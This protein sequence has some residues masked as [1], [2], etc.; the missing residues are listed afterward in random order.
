MVLQ[1]INF[2]ISSVEFPFYFP[3]NFLFFLSF[4]LRLLRAA[5]S[6]ALVS[7]SSFRLDS[8]GLLCPL[9]LLRVA[10]SSPASSR[11]LDLP[12]RSPP[13]RSRS[14]VLS[15]PPL[16]DE[17]DLLEPT[18]APPLPVAASES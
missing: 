12:R 15:C 16:D 11:D 6:S 4:H 9:L 5:S 7:P 18:P 13:P 8:R 14:A 3:R 10:P 1:E 17:D 2:L